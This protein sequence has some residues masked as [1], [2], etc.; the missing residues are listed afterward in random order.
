MSSAQDV[1]RGVETQW[2]DLPR[3]VSWRYVSLPR[4]GTCRIDKRR[5]DLTLVLS[6]E[7]CRVPDV[8]QVEAWLVKLLSTPTT[9]EEVALA[10]YAAF[11]IRAEAKGQTATHGEISATVG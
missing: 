10:A 7:V 11:G 3:P 2:I 9:V 4:R 8:L 1:G 6:G 5:F